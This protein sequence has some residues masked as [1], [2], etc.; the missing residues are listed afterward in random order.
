[1]H[2]EGGTRLHP[3]HQVLQIEEEDDGLIG[4]NQKPPADGAAAFFGRPK[5]RHGA[6]A[7]LAAPKSGF[8]AA[9]FARDTPPCNRS[10]LLFSVFSA[11]SVPLCRA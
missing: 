7:F 10:C 8:S 5:N 2:R 6:A 11:P 1:M 3:L 9:A 4:G